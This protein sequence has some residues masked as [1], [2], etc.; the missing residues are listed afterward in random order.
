MFE[1]ITQTIYSLINTSL[2]AVYP[3][4]PS[5][6]KEE[7]SS[8]PFIKVTI[9]FSRAERYAYK[10]KK[11]INGMLLLSVFYPSGEGQLD[12]SRIAD[13]LDLIFQDRLLLPNLQFYLG[14]AQFLGPDKDDNSLSR[15]DY[16]IPFCYYGE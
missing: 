16:S 6:Y 4:Y 8:V 5:D 15:M 9:V 7:P 3:T 11:E 14:S 10:D 13:E 12:A 1:E 2:A